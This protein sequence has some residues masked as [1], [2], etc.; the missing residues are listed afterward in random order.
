MDGE[1][2]FTSPNLPVAVESRMYGIEHVR[3]YLEKEIGENTL[4]KVF[5]ILLNSSDEILSDG[6]TEVLEERLKHLLT[7]FQVRRYI[8]DF[9]TLVFYE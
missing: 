2:T 7:V 4:M 9:T 6:G 8:N 3:E 1:F 5:P